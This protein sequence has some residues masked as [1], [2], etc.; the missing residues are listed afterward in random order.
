[1]EI[2]IIL[3]ILGGIY[4]FKNAGVAPIA[5]PVITNPSGTQQSS[6]PANVPIITIPAPV[7]GTTSTTV[8]TDN[9]T[10]EVITTTVKATTPPHMK[11]NALLLSDS[12]IA[13]MNFSIGFSSSDR[14]RFISELLPLLQIE[15]ISYPALNNQC[16][17]GNHYSGPPMALTTLKD[18]SLALNSAAGIGGALGGTFGSTSGFAGTGF[19]A[20][21]TALGTAIPIIGIAI[22]AAISI[23]SVIAAHHAAAVKNEQGLECQLMPPANYTLQV[24]EQAV[25]T[26][27]ITPAQGQSALTTLLSDFKR[28]ASNGASGQYSESSGHCNAMCW[29]YHF[30]SAIVMKKQNRYAQYLTN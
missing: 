3:A 22:G 19:A 7:S 21:G 29:Y 10:G 24:I 18:G 9:A 27:N 26:G 17:S 6:L 12:Q 28:A 8:T 16:S 30:L 5:T 1:M 11:P 14:K 23:Y 2:V 13:N 25:V 15:Q 20:A 4:L